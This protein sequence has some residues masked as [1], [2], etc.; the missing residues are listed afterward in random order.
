MKKY[1][2][3]SA[4]FL[5]LGA[6]SQQNANGTQNSSSSSS[7]PDYA[8]VQTP[9]LTRTYTDPKKQFSI[10]YPEN[11]IVKKNDTLNGNEYEIKGGTSFVF[12]AS[13]APNTTLIDAKVN[14]GTSVTC[15]PLDHP[16]Q[17]VIGGYP[18]NT[19]TWTD[20]AAGNLYEGTVYTSYKDGKC[21][22]A[23]L[24]IHSC[25]LGPDC[26]PGHTQTFARIPMKALFYKMMQTFRFASETGT[27][28]TSA[29]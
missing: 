26:A 25:N 13:Y 7:A 11:F 8:S 12:P 17:S 21:Y 1:L 20:V 22:V 4:A 16:D 6:C 14:I 19:S 24:D 27:G 9:E 18:F 5:T 10:H 3:L 2:L 23:T 29:S 15:P 28:T